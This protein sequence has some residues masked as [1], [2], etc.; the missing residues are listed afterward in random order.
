MA[1]IRAVIIHPDGTIQDTE[2]ENGLGPY[3]AVVGGYIEGVF[4][5]VATIYVNEEGLLLRL[6]LNPVATYFAQF[7]LGRNVVLHGTALIV[8]PGDGEGDDT[9]VR[10]TVVDF[11]TKEN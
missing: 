11:F 4:G 9:S 7:I 10:Q 3:Q 5:N 2:I 6:P 8:G 1:S